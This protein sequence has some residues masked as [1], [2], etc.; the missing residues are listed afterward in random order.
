MVPLNGGTPVVA[1]VYNTALDNEN[2]IDFKQHDPPC[3]APGFLRGQDGFREI[4]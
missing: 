3:L 1:L 4:Q 2:P